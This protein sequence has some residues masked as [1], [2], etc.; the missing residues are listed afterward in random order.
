MSSS[1]DNNYMELML[2]IEDNEVY[3]KN[4]DIC[5]CD[6][7]LQLHYAIISQILNMDNHWIP[8]IKNYSCLYCYNE[9]HIE[10]KED[11]TISMGAVAASIA[12]ESTHAYYD[13]DYNGYY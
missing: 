8:I 12:H 10:K 3:D 6:K 5:I 2:D 1:K 4:K 7:S 9:F 13:Y 11:K